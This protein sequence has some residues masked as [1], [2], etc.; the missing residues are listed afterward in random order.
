MK[1]RR[2]FRATNVILPA[3]CRGKSSLSVIAMMLVLFCSSAAK[4]QT[5]TG[6]LT[7]TVYDEGGAAVPNSTLTLTN[8]TTG[9]VRTTQSNSQGIFTVPDL[10][11]SDYGFSATA[12][13]FSTETTTLTITLGQ[14]STFDVHLK[15]GSVTQTVEV[16]AS[17]SELLLEKDSHEVGSFLQAVAVESLPANGRDL[18]QTLQAAANVNSYM[19]A[20]GD[21]IGYFS[22]QA[23]SLTIG[24]AAPG[25]TSYLQDGVSNFNLVAKAANLEP[26]IESIQEVSL[27]ASGAGARYDEPSIVNVITKSGGRQFHGR[28]YDYLKND[29]LNTTGYFKVAKPPLRY[30]QFG[31]NIGGPLFRNKLF[32]FFDYAGLRYDLGQTLHAVVPT[33][34]ERAGDFS[35]D[36]TIYDPSTYNATTKTISPFAGN[37]LPAISNFGQLLLG[38]YPLP[39]P[40]AVAGFNYQKTASQ[41]TNYNLYLGRLDYTIGA[42]DSMYGSYA[43]SNPVIAS[44]NFSTS[45]IFNLDTV[46]EA[47]NA[48]VGEEHTFGSHLINVARFGYNYSDMSVTQQGAGQKDYITDYGIQNLNPQMNLW[49]PPTIVVTPVTGIGTPNNP[50]GAFQHL[51]AYIDEATWTVGRHS[52]YIG[53]EL[54]RINL[55]RFSADYNNGYYTFTGQFTSDHGVT[56][57]STSKLAGGNTLADFE[58]GDPT[59]SQGGVGNTLANFT[60][61]NVMPYIQDDFKVSNKLVLNLGLRYDYYTSPTASISSVYD[62]PTN[63]N[64]PGS[65]LQN[66]LNFAPRVGFAYTVTPTM[67]VHGGYGIYY[68]PFQY[69]MLTFLLI[70][71]P[72]FQLQNY[73]YPITGAPVYAANAFS[74]NVSGSSMAPFTLALHMPTP[75]V[76]EWNLAI[77]RTL[78]PNWIASASYLGN[79]FTHQEIRHNPN[80]G[81]DLGFNAA[82]RPYSYVGDVYEGADI[83]YAKYNAGQLELQRHYVNGISVDASYVWSE[84]MDVQSSGDIPPTNGRNISLDYGRSDY[85]PEHAFKLSG[86]YQLPFG[87]GRAYLHDN[88]WFEREVVGGWQLSDIFTVFSGLPFSTSAADLSGSGTYHAMRANQICDGNSGAPRTFAQ[89]FNTACFTKPGVGQLGNERKNNL[90]GPRNTNLDISLSK[91]FPVWK[92]DAVQF[93]SDFFDV[94]NHPLPQAPASSIATASTFGQITSVPGVRSVQLSVKVIF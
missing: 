2:F 32:F 67:A 51:Y 63:T 81:I 42:N 62:V 55:T 31:A 12:P 58:L 20:S 29:D 66:S 80:Q 68:T 3:A 85:N 70:H 91:Q 11:P 18:F 38:Y 71:A 52:I 30:N 36:A 53:G 60:Q 47:S 82:P 84:S 64:H 35:A 72:N 8:R 76:Q 87:P 90:T 50:N 33:V 54:D 13:G 37:K 23:E 27:I 45:T 57:G 5:T 77:Q 34:A 1:I 9:A 26:S 40:S 61:W 10:N 89:W 28:V 44:P 74:A 92:E 39:T 49:M 16:N 24:G 93:R 86:V 14:V 75:Y 25:T 78:G 41:T 83:G 79:K 43:T 17:E 65:Y 59:Q 88:H 15:V 56:S 7:G 48:Y 21:N 69:Q 73:T 94:L 6:S 46:Q 22:L 4:A 19:G